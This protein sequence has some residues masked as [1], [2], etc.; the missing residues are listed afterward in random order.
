MTTFLRNATIID[1]SGGKPF[2][3]TIGIDGER[4][5]TVARGKE[6][7]AAKPGDEVIDCTGLTIM[8]GLTEAHCHISFNNL[9]SMYQAVEIQPEDHSLVALANAQMLLQ[10]GFTSLFSAASAK[11]RVDVA[12]RDAINRG[13][14]EGPR[15]RAAGQEI[16]PSGNLGD[17]DNNYLTFPRNVRFT[18]TCDGADEFTKAAR[19][20]ARDGVDTIKVNVSGDRDWGHMHADDS[21]TVIAERELAAVM[22]VANARKLMV[23]TH[24][25]SSSGVKM[26]VRQGVQVIYHAPHADSE[27]RDMLEAAKDRV[28]VAPAAGLPISM[29]RRYKEF[30]LGWSADKVRSMEIE[31]ETVTRCMSDL[32]RRGVRVLPGG[33]YGAFITNPIGDN[34][35][36]LEH[37]VDLFGF[38]PMAAIVAATRQGAE[39]MGMAHETGQIKPGF[40]ADLLIVS[41]DPLKD[42]RILQDQDRILGVMKGGRFARRQPSLGRAAPGQRK[43]A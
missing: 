22:E 29:L 43:A 17:L 23:A 21:V 13:L 11:P 35:R 33:D 30:G 40:F 24:C 3:G 26:C 27:A 36:D 4:I 37:F 28:F 5:E 9:S 32:H 16:S 42:I 6:A 38:T 7:A 19:L 18:V 12:V 2:A 15:M 1:A 34:A 14:F 31:V 25:T 10:R 20:A 41:G 8:P 39:L